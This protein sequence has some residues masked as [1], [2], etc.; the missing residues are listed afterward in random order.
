[1]ADSNQIHTY[2]ANGGSLYCGTC[3]HGYCHSYASFYLVSG[4][5]GGAMDASNLLK[6][7]FGRGELRCIEQQH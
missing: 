6:P 1:V 3:L 2:S 5:A 7:M 4:A